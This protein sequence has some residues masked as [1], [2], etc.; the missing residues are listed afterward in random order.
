MHRTLAAVYS[1]LALAG[2]AV[3]QDGVFQ[4]R[5]LTPDTALV[6]ARAALDACRKQGYQVAVAVVDR[7]G[8]TQ[9]MLRDRYAGAHTVDVA[10]NKAWTAASFR[11]ATTALAADTQPGKAMS[12]LRGLPRF[13]PAGGGLVIEGG[14]TV[15]GAIGVSGGPGGDADDACARAGIKAI[16]DAIE[17]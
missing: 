16:A 17:F 9:V 14:G 2:A 7:A 15:F 12:G 11:T 1:V 10:Q 3:A 6:A 5:S 13:L 8:L 4:I